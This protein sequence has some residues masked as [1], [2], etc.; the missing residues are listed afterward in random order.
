MT[1][2]HLEPIVD[3]VGDAP[4]LHG[5]RGELDPE[6]P[7]ACLCGGAA[8]YMECPQYLETGGIGRFMIGLDPD[9][10]VYAEHPDLPGTVKACADAAYCAL[11]GA[12]SQC[13]PT[14]VT[15]GY[16]YDSDNH[17]HVWNR[18]RTLP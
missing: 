3:W 9:G 6:H 7:S 10:T 18:P 15:P 14:G 12:C 2:A 11:C 13:D 8:Q 17:K 4:L 5:E 1:M 16:C